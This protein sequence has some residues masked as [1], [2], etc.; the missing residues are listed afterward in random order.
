MCYI[1]I[2][3]KP[4]KELYY[5][6]II[7][8]NTKTKKYITRLLQVQ[9]QAIDNDLTELLNKINTILF[10]INEKWRDKMLSTNE[11]DYTCKGYRQII[12]S[13]CYKF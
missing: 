3:A 1:V 9:Q 2:V 10:T 4:H 13:T 12:K 6:K 11:I 5:M 8:L 7:K